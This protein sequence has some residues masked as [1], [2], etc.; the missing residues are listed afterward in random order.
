MVCKRGLSA[1]VSECLLA[2]VCWAPAGS[3]AP[4]RALG[5]EQAPCSSKLTGEQ[6]QVQTAVMWAVDGHGR[7]SPGA[8]AWPGGE[9][10][11]AYREIKSHALESVS[12][13]CRP[14]AEIAVQVTV[15]SGV[16]GAPASLPA[17][18]V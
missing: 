15:A 13:G 2:S 6:T 11:G 9:Q 4:C 3:Q 17:P 18:A 14:T 5:L 1:E 16:L 12:A 8:A 7:D 10:G